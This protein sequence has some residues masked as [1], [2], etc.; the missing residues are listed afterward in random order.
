MRLRVKVI[1]KG[2]K[3]GSVGKQRRA[4]LAPSLRYPRIADFRFAIHGFSKARQRCVFSGVL[5]FELQNGKPA[6]LLELARASR[7]SLCSFSPLAVK[8]QVMI[9]SH[10]SKWRRTRTW[11]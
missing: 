3:I 10:K 2:G 6:E 1:Y 4:N 9:E 5:R 8:G 11:Q 7:L